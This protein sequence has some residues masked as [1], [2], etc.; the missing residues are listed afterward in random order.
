MN[1]KDFISMFLMLFQ[2]HRVNM[3]FF[4]ITFIKKAIIPYTHPYGNQKRETGYDNEH[5]QKRRIRFD[6]T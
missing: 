5:D 4:L 3:I 2:R 1:I 6:L